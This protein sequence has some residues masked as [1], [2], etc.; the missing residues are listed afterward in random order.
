[1]TLFGQWRVKTVKQDDLRPK[2]KSFEILKLL[3]YNREIASDL[4]SILVVFLIRVY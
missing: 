1:M 4:G 3:I 2:A